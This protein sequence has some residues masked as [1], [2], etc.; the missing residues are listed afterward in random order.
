MARELGD[1]PAVEIETSTNRL[2]REDE[3][4]ASDDDD[5]K[6]R[7]V[8]S[9]KEKTQRQKIAEEIGWYLMII[10]HS[11]IIWD[12]AV[13]VKHVMSTLFIILTPNVLIPQ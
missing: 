11:V 7:I 12:F 4:D 9:V 6:R 13:K 10:I 1:C 5:E 3:N 8:F 2:V